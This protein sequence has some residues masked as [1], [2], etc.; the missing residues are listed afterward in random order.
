MYGFCR[1]LGVAMVLAGLV[2]QAQLV[3]AAPGDNLA[4]FDAVVTAGIPACSV[5][6]GIAYDGTNLILSCYQSNVLQRVNASSHLNGGAV[7]IT[8]LPGGDSLGALAW[9]ATRNRLWACNDF[10]QVVLINVGAGAVDISQPAIPVVGC[11]DGLA[12]DASD[13]TLWVSADASSTTCHYQT[14]GVQIGC[15]SNS[16]LLGSCGNS[17]IAVGG[18]SLYLANNGCSE[19]YQL[20]K[21]FASSTLFASFPARLE[22]LECDGRTFA[23]NGAIWS[24]DAYDRVL[25]AWEIPPGQCAFGGLGACGDGNP[26][27]G[28]QCDDGN[29]VN[30]DGC[31]ANCQI[32]V[33]QECGDGTL[34]PPEVC[35]PPGSLT[36]P[37][38][39]SPGGAFLA[40]NA[41][42]TCPGPV[43]CGDGDVQGSEECDPP[44]S[45]TCGSVGG[46]FLACRADCT[47]A[48][49]NVDSDCNDQDACTADECENG[50]CMHEPL[51]NLPAEQDCV[52]MEDNDCDG[53]VDCAD[54]DCGDPNGSP[55]CVGGSQNN[56]SCASEDLS[57]ACENG[58]GECRCGNIVK[59]PS[60]IRFGEPLD[61]FKS[62][63]RIISVASIDVGASP[64]GWVLS[65]GSGTIYRGVLNPGDFQSNGDGTTFIYRDSD[66][67]LGLGK[68]DGIYKA[69]IRIS[70]G[71]TSYG[72]KIIAYG[73]LSAATTPNMSLQFYINQPARAFIHDKPWIRK[74]WGWKATPFD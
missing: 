56:K 13:D 48:E 49:C 7:A 9:D 43:T 25:N 21:T 73:D 68:R 4:Q 65:N 8:G 23:P 35:D 69:K 71:G 46:A 45:L 52:D 26:D 1:S 63:G 62:H 20:P 57:L 29:L 33:P 28:E 10:S 14:N 30:G 74:S 36:C 50:T 54:P 42:C 5:G 11:F 38:P 61:V 6:V 37:D 34:Q 60:T 72:Y 55:V 27:P 51:T 64:V 18:T 67:R 3:K 58:G 47:C 59:D 32:E 41:N 15:F 40:C 24:L 17:G 12:Y 70:R 31:D 22:D 16:G 44:G 2:G 66:A 53:L 39:S 19:I